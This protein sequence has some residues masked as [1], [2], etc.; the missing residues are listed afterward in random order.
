MSYIQRL[1][2]S[3]ANVVDETCGLWTHLTLA[4]WALDSAILFNQT[5]M[6]LNNDA[7]VTVGV[8]Q[9]LMT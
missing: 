7:H 8:D 4:S 6:P 1:E 9:K 3:H 5:W 2:A